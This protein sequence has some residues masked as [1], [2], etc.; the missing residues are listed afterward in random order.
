MAGSN[1]RLTA[2]YDNQISIFLTQCVEGDQYVI[3]L[4]DLYAHYRK[5]MHQGALQ[6]AS[7]YRGYYC[8]KIMTMS[9]FHSRLLSAGVDGEEEVGIG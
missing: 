6:Q 3:P 5:L 9:S 7:K 1:N 8:R 4:Q 2:E